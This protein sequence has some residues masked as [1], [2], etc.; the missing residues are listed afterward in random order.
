[1]ATGLTKIGVVKN[2]RVGLFM[3]NCPQYVMLYYAILKA[4]GTVVNF[5]PLYSGHEIAHELKDAN[6]EIIATVNLRATYDKLT[7]FIGNSTLRK[8]IMCNFGEAMPMTKRA[9]FM[10]AKAKDIAHAPH[11]S[12]HVTLNTL[13]E[14]NEMVTPVNIIP[15]SHIAVLQY[16]GGT[17]GTPKGALLSHANLYCNTMQCSSWMVGLTPGKETMLAV[18]P[19]F[20]VF[21]MTVALNLAI[22]NGF[23]IIIH[24]KFDLKHVLSD[25]TQKKPTIMPGVSTLYATINNARNLDKYDLSSIKMCISGGGP[26]PVEVKLQFEKLTGCTL[27]EG[28]GL[29]E[30]SPVTHCNPLVGT[31]KTGSI[32]LP[33]PGTMAEVID[34]DDRVTPMK[35]GEIG[36][37]CIRGPQLMLGYLNRPDETDHVLRAG[38]LHTGDLG[39]VDADG[40]FYIVDRLKEMIIVGGYNVYPRNV[41]EEIYAHPAVAEC[42]VI[43][44]EHPTRGQMIKA[45]IVLKEGGTLDE[46]ELKAHLK[47]R[48]TAYALPHAVEFRSELPKNNI[49]KI[50]KRAL[51]E[52]E[53]KKHA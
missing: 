28:Y 47:P 5:N 3:P 43:G 22:A 1:I 9:L 42:A 14:S 31:N 18:I 33:L 7:P 34:K 13:L 25:I 16:T 17:T 35:Q 2:T 52:E 50:L 19:F 45:Y 32:G 37:I 30:T 26:L 36:E 6:V 24:P 11:D 15:Q 51:V 49:G 53:K 4:G 41:E 27:V 46:A 10:A 8:I 40:Y 12:Y 48:I 44:L 20:H 38:R 23:T 21:A 39:Y 29:T